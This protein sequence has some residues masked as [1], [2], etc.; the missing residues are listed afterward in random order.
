MN[1]PP[2]RAK[3][4]EIRLKNASLTE[5]NAKYMH[6]KMISRTIGNMSFKVF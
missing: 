6:M 4:I 1:A 2:M 3:G 5:W